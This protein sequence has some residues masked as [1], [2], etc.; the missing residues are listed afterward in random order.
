MSDSRHKNPPPTDEE[1]DVTPLFRETVRE[2][3]KT[4]ARKN[5][6]SGFHKNE[7]GYLISNHAELAEAIGTDKTMVNKIIGPVRPTTKVKLVTRSAFLA[8]IRDALGLAPVARITVKASRLE[9]MLAIAELE[10][11]DFAALT[12]RLKSDR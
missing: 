9:Q 4:N 1:E 3:L 10:D 6:L 7:P 8:R 12:K 5:R 2:M 11:D